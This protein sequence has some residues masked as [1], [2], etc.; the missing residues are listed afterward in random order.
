M[1]VGIDHKLLCPANK[2][3]VDMSLGHRRN[4]QTIFLSE[5]LITVDITLRVDDKR[6]ARTLTAH[7]IGILGKVGIKNLTE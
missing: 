4:A 1:N 7:Q 2:I 6:F 3:G 5:K